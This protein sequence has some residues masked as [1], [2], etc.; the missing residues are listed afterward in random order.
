MENEPVD[1]IS[2]ITHE[3]TFSRKRYVHQKNFWKNRKDKA[4][5]RNS[6][7]LTIVLRKSDDY[8]EWLVL[9][10]KPFADEGEPSTKDKVNWTSFEYFEAFNTKKD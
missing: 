7:K 5:E 8:D 9:I 2:S 6:D 3:K 1:T 4:A 10:L